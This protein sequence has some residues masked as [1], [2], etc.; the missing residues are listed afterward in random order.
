MKISIDN[1]LPSGDI[2]FID[3]SAYIF[4]WRLLHCNY[5][6]GYLKRRSDKKVNR[7]DVA[8]FLPVMKQ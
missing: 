8:L 3:V 5:K 4:S 2:I 1:S 7:K 6:R